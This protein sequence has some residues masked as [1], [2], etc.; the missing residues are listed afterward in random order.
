MRRLFFRYA[1]RTQRGAK[2]RRGGWG[3][4]VGGRDRSD[5]QQTRDEASGY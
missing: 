1:V 5:A 4:Q 2:P 3:L